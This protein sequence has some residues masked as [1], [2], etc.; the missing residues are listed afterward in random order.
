LDDS[1]NFIFIFYRSKRSYI[2]SAAA[3]RIGEC[4]IIFILIGRNRA[5]KK[6]CVKCRCIYEYIMSRDIT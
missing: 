2:N 6:Y 3:H 1:L 5:V 4:K